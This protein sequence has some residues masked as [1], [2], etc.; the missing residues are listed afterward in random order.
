MSFSENAMAPLLAQLW[1]Q[2]DLIEFLKVSW[3]LYTK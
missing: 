3:I 1:N 2:S